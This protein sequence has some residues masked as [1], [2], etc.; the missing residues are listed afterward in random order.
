MKARLFSPATWRA[1]ILAA[2][3]R[4]P[5]AILCG[6]IGSAC[7]IIGI[8][9][10]QDAELVNQSARL[11][12]T[13]ALGLPLFFSLRIL[14]EREP[15]WTRWPLELLGIPL[16]AWWFF[17]HHTRLSDEP[18]I[19]F[20]RWALLLA[21]LHCFAAVSA[22]VRR[23]AVAGFWQFNRKLFVRF[24]LTT[25]YTGV[26]TAGLE[27]ALLSADKLFELHL[28]RAYA[29]LWF[30]MVGCF[31]P[32]FFL[33]G[34]P[35]DF[36]QL[37]VD[38][39]HPRGLKAF[40]Q[41][42]LAPLVLVYGLILYAYA[43][44]IIL[45]R[46]WPHGWVA[47]PVLVL[48][49]IGIFASLL[50]HPLRSDPAERWAVWFGR[51]FPP[52]LAPLAVL[53]LLSV[54]IRIADYGVTEER[55]AGIVASLWI[56]TWSVVFTVRQ[57]SGIRWIP[58]SL[59][60]IALALG[61]GPWSAGAVSKKSQLN[62]VVQMLE[63]QGL[64]TGNAAK[65][66]ERTT[67]LSMEQGKSLRSTIGY[68]IEMHGVGTV[69]PIFSSIMADAEWAKLER[70]TGASAIMDALH[71]KV[72]AE[73]SFRHYARNKAAAVDVSGYRRMWALNDLYSGKT[74]DW[75]EHKCDELRIGLDHGVLKFALSPEMAP[76]P[77][78]LEDLLARLPPVPTETLSNEA[79]T[80]DFERAGR[81]FRIVFSAIGV[82][83]GAEQIV[84]DTADL[85]LLER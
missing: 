61:F 16:L 3:Q 55:Y 4:F 75:Q 37:E 32:T 77:V 11:A 21:A 74:S 72:A 63:V 1:G 36:A 23:T 20:I 73:Q 78:P 50:L 48:S 64:W 22:N 46:S 44:K 8:H 68:L 45:L 26:L 52:A 49:G 59:A 13:V 5:F 41:F 34:V 80:V 67:E 79:M 57:K 33:A 83:G 65:A 66:A 27:L 82:Q 85:L 71:I 51:V 18:E 84:I 39:E 76:E 17:A 29:D 70:W 54:R 53:L 69:K 12:M 35:R 62:R 25:L 40:T 19:V 81:A 60:L 10:D 15:R 56:I 6:A 7:G 2:F 58:A 14:R 42:A 31:H 47:L 24:C 28:N 9:R 43:G 30:L 38:T